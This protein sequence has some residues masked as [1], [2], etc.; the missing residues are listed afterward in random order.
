[1]QYGG[2]KF[3]FKLSMLYFLIYIAFTLIINRAQGQSTSKCDI[4]TKEFMSPTQLISGQAS[5]CPHLLKL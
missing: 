2:K 1:M 3:P 5:I 4:V